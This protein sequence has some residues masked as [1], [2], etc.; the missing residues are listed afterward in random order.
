MYLTNDIGSSD[1]SNIIVEASDASIMMHIREI[2]NGSVKREA[3]ISMD[4]YLV[5]QLI[6]Y[7]IANK[8]NIK[9][10][11]EVWADRKAND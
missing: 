7:L 1:A 6:E 8:P 4:R 3:R 11:S 10:H 9:T 2:C 5:T